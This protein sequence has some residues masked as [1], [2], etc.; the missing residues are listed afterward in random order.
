MDDKGRSR[1]GD[2]I[3]GATLMLTNGNAPGV[4]L[5]SR[6]PRVWSE[7][8]T[9]IRTV[10]PRWETW[11]MLDLDDHHLPTAIRLLLAMCMLLGNGTVAAQTPVDPCKLQARAICIGAKL[12]NANLSRKR[13]NDSDFSGADLSNANLTGADLYS[14]DLSRAD[15]SG[16]VLAE[17]V[18]GRATLVDADLSAANLRAANLRAADLKGANLSN[19][20]LS[21][22][23]LTYANLT[24]AT[25][26]DGRVCDTASIG[27][28]R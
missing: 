5:R 13:L 27:L 9:M 24:G 25:W 15:L 6:L 21:Q 11:R 1:P 16:A 19:A 26:T 8:S 20:N 18:L 28:C 12:A 23:D 2:R 3:R 7:R 22:A 17:A 10:L 14:A 4:R